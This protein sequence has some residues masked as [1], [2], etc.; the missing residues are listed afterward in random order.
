MLDNLQKPN[1]DKKTII[2]ADDE[3]AV[4]DLLELNI[5]QILPD[6]KLYK[7]T[8]SIDA[9]TRLKEGKI[10]ALVT[11]GEL[12]SLTGGLNGIQLAEKAINSG[13]SPEMIYIFTGNPHDYRDKANQLKVKVLPKPLG[14]KAL[15]GYLDFYLNHS[16][17]V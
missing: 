3:M 1:G 14:L 9:L 8:K 15:K 16:A 6:Y 13:I 11:D 2:L 17:L 5:L 7:E 4:L 12:D 10:A